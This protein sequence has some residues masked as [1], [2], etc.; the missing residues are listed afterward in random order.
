MTSSFSEDAADRD[1]PQC[2]TSSQVSSWP[3]HLVEQGEEGG[4][5]WGAVLVLVA[6]VVAVVVAVMPVVVIVFVVRKV[7]LVLLSNHSFFVF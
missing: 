7:M 5:C 2:G 3:Q 1:H 6:M 4:G